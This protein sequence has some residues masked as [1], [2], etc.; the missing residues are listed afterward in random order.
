MA[1]AVINDGRCL[2]PTCSSPGP[3]TTFKL[4]AVKKLIDCATERHDNETRH[5]MQTMLDSQGEQ[6]SVELHK[7]CYCSFTSKSNVKKRVAKKRKDGSIDSDEGPVARLR[8]SQAIEFDFK[9]QC[10]FCAQACEPVN[11]KHPDRWDRVIQCERKGAKDSQQ[12]KTAVLKYCGDRNDVW[13][14]KVAIRCHGM[15]DLA[16]AEAQ[17]HIRCY[18]EFR[19][20]PVHA[21]QTPVIDDQAMQKLVDEMHANRQLRTWTSIELHD[22]YVSYG[23]Q[24]T[25]K[26][27]FT[28]LITHLGDDVVVL[29]IEGCASIVGFRS[30]V[31]TILKVAKVDT[32]DEEKE[33]ALVRKITTEARGIPFNNKTY[34]LGYFTHTKTKQHTSSTLLM[35]VSKLIS[36]GGVT[37]ASLSLSQ[38]IQYGITK[39]RNQTTLGLG[40]KLHHKYGSSDLIHTLHEHGYTVPYDEVLRFRKS[41]AKYVSDNAAT[42]HRMM[43]LKRTVGLV[44]GWYDSFYQLDRRHLKR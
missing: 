43:G 4:Q 40:V 37:K 1:E 8:R 36:N 38:S 25:R 5:R 11:P 16:A 27:L 33:D 10:L 3:H 22:K 7:T 2:L 6:A 29:Q 26:Q 17:Y 30:F 21:D 41:A 14:R 31:G 28:K 23:G 42:L 13:S 9:A 44:F 34:E 24:L 32:V 15:H 39:T 19:K 35:F 12:F 20:I 18:D